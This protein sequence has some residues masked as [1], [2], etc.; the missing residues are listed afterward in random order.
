MVWDRI[1]VAWEYKGE[2]LRSVKVDIRIQRPVGVEKSSW[3]LVDADREYQKP[4][5]YF[6]SY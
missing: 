6:Y 2:V 4:M 3:K 1:D 5:L